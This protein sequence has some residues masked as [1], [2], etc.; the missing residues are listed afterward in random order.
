MK[1]EV[2]RVGMQFLRRPKAPSVRI[3]DPIPGVGPYVSF[4]ADALEVEAAVGLRGNAIG[5]RLGWTQ[6]Q[7][8]DVNRALFRG[9]TREAGRVEVLRDQSKMATSRLCRDVSFAS[10]VF[11]CPPGTQRGLGYT[12]QRPMNLDLT[13][14]HLPGTVRVSH[15][16]KPSEGYIATQQNDRTKRPNY[17]AW[18]LVEMQFCA[19]LLLKHRDHRL[20]QLGHFTW[21][22]RWENRF[23]PVIQGRK[24]TNIRRT[25]G[26]SGNTVTVKPF[27][28]RPVTD[29]RFAALINATNSQTCNER[30]YL[31]NNNPVV[32]QHLSW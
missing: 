19:V 7:S 31:R 15:A 20:V 16:D 25:S 24:V 22:L 28:D 21:G 17:L 18:A 27:V 13:S 9:L 12:P 29:V 4:D 30:A 10:D 6:L 11:T 1:L 26:D 2:D 3:G 5:A 14:V 23:E 8:V 32:H